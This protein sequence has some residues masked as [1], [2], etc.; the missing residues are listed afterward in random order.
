MFDPEAQSS[1]DWANGDAPFIIS[2]DQILPVH[3]AIWEVY[4]SEIC[5]IYPFR[6]HRLC[7]VSFPISK[8]RPGAT[9]CAFAAQLALL[10][11]L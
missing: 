7:L 3:V 4:Y 8:L 11:F 2:I 1:C 6:D 10:C 5:T 9:L